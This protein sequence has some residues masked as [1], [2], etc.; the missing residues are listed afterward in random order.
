[1]EIPMAQRRSVGYWFEE[2]PLTRA[3]WIAGLVLFVSFVIESW[4]MMIIIFNG[5]SIGAEFALGTPEI[6][7]LIGAMFLGM[8]PGALVWGKLIDRFGRKT[9]LVA[10]LALYSPLPL[11]CVLAADFHVLWWLRFIGG[12]VFSGVLVVTFPFFEEL[13]PVKSRGRATVFLSAGWPLGVLVAIGVTILLGDAGWR[14]VIGM[15][16]TTGLWAIVVWAAIPESPYWLAEK[17]RTRESEISIAWLS[18]KIVDARVQPMEI[19]GHADGKTSFFDIFRRE[20]VAITALQVTINFCF[21]WGYWGLS[22]WMPSLLAQKG[23]SAPQ[24]LSFIALSALFMFPGYI[25]ASFLTGRFGR[26]PIMAIFVLVAAAAGFGFAN[27]ES[28]IQMYVWNFTLSFFSLGA[29]GIWNT[30]MA[31]LYP[32]DT[33]SAGY[34]LGVSAQRIANAVAPIMIG[35]MLA[36][37]SFLQTVTFISA[38]LAVTFVCALFLP[39]TEGKTLT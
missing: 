28:L 1:M 11:L 2:M 10:S 18:R 39:E 3:H 29:W 23:L 8:I 15:S 38:F 17:G 7:Q 32:T 30:W 16:A 21:A 6:G 5:A 25:A 19:P 22:S 12:F 20:I 26:K 33:R 14:W 24:G 34:S 37:A 27:S 13:L 36:S 35:A 31:E 4:E 9:C